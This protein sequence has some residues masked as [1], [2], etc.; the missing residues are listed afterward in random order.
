MAHYAEIYNN[1][2]IQVLVMDNDIETNQ[3]EQSC[4]D[5]LQINVSS[6]E[7]IK[8]SYN[9]NI[10]KQYAGI[11]YTYYEAV[12]EFVSPQPF[13]S[14]SLDNNNDW[15]PPTPMPEGVYTWDEDTLSWIEAAP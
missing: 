2:V 3:G 12:D 1:V 14:W 7:W 8:T 9:N 6:N 15:Q 13:A 4:V 11:G 10:R 5:W